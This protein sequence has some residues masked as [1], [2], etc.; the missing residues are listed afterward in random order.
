MTAFW[1]V[2]ACLLAGAL[3]FLL[4]PLLQRSTARASIAQSEANLSVYRAQLDELAADVAAGTLD[5]TQYESSRHE[6]ERRLLQ[7]V[8]VDSSAGPSAAPAGRWP[9]ALLGAAVPLVAVLLYLHLGSPALI[10]QQTKSAPASGATHA[11]DRQQIE[12][13]VDG[14]ARRLAANPQDPDGWIMLARSYTV[15]RRYDDANAAYARAVEQRPGDAQV[16]ADYADTLAMLQGKRLAGAP[17]A[18]I[19]RALRA[20]PKNMKALA[21][22][23]TEAYERRDYARAG[24][25]WQRLLALAPPGSELARS[26]QA[27]VQEARALAAGAPSA[28]AATRAA[29]GS[30][31]ITGTVRLSP[32]LA[33]K[34]APDDIVFI[35]ARAVQ[36]PRMP[37]AVL[38]RQVKDLP[39][40]FVLDDSL[41]MAAG[42]TLSAY[43]EVVVGAR[44]SR[45]GSATPR[46]GDLQGI[47]QP[48]LVGATDVRIVIDSVVP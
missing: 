20:D 38:R 23:G 32:A 2:G 19:Q 18:L 39:T 9:A 14:L 30:A 35:S 44:V 31:R 37:L 13:M 29:A 41:A 4:P 45:A 28:S 46:P 11:M 47:V 22:A 5:T 42:M 21:L 12:Q 24:D 40:A 15:L 8:P 48:V 7:D 1:I 26:V 6:L 17:A 16:L 27:N 25:Y 33:S 43:P 34:A 3:L 36:G 10:A